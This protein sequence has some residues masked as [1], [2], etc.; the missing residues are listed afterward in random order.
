M[1]TQTEIHVPALM[2][3]AGHYQHIKTMVENDEMSKLV[4]NSSRQFH[5][6]LRRCA[7]DAGRTDEYEQAV[8]A[9]S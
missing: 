8:S 6:L 1:P 2:D 4:R 7:A 9:L 3:G 5:G